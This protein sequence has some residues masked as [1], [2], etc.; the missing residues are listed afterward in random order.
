MTSIWNI[1]KE[2]TVYGL[3]AQQSSTEIL[4]DFLL[5]RTKVTKRDERGHHVSYI[6][7]CLLRHPG[8]RSLETTYRGNVPVEGDRKVSRRREVRRMIV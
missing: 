8:G 7:P 3:Q 4:C 2:E 5:S 1:Y 6:V